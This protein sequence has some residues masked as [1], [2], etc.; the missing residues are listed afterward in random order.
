MKNERLV[1]GLARVDWFRVAQ[2]L[3]V[4]CR[5]MRGDDAATI[6]QETEREIE[7]SSQLR[8]SIESFVDKMKGTP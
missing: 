4:F 6:R 5:E 7:R 3:A 1:S 2:R 8:N